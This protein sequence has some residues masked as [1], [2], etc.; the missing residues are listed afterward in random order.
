MHKYIKTQLYCVIVLLPNTGRPENVMC[1][2]HASR[3]Q[4]NTCQ[5]DGTALC[6]QCPASSVLDGPACRAPVAPGCISSSRAGADECLDLAV[7]ALNLFYSSCKSN[8]SP[9]SSVLPARGCTHP[10]SASRH[11]F[12]AASD[13]AHF[14]SVLGLNILTTVHY[15][16]NTIMT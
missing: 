9:F 2:T 5:A 11:S 8:W 15:P 4:R 3:A 7:P 12:S 6:A 10:A 1:C 13:R 14:A 16:I